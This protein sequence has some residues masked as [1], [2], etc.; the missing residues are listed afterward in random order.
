MLFSFLL[1]FF[2]FAKDTGS[3]AALRNPQFFNIDVPVT[4]S[5]WF[6]LQQTLEVSSIFMNTDSLSFHDT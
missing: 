4:M 6:V 3:L 5:I 2:F 1:G